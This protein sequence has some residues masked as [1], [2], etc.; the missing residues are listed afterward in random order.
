M[1]PHVRP[2]LAH[3]LNRIAGQVAGLQKML[4]EDRYCVDLLTQLAAIR[5]ALDALGVELLANHLQ[6]CV[7]GDASTQHP[8]AR[9]LTREQLVEEVRITLGRF[10]R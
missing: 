4:A 2:D 6:S 1:S 10:L 8:C 7:T 9:K 3:R 5:S